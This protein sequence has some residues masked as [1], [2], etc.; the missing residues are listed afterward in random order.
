MSNARK[1]LFQMIED[2]KT[3]MFTT[4]RGDG[5]LVSRP[6]ANQERSSGADLW[7]VTYAGSP[8][9]RELERNPQVNLT[10]YKDRTR[11][12][13]SISGRARISR[14]RAK[15]RELFKPDWRAWFADDGGPKAGTP[16][17]PRI[18]LIGVTIRSVVFMEQD[19]PAPV[20]IFEV[21]KG[22]VTRKPPKLGKMHKLTS[23]P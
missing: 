9:L 5:R 7:F 21:A 23:R 13:V 10:Y 14:N 15:I 12:W 2:M 17:D 11:E 16:D 3:A 6:M 19:K 20:A 22:I 4:R 1:K 8:K 18:V